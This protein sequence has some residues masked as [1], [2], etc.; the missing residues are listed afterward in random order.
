MTERRNRA[1]NGGTSIA[2]R[3]QGFSLRT[4]LIGLVLGA[5][6]LSLIV[7]VV[8]STQYVKT[9][10][11]KEINQAGK[12]L[13]TVLSLLDPSYFREIRGETG[14]VTGELQKVLEKQRKR[15]KDH[16]KEIR[17]SLKNIQ[18][19]TRNIETFIRKI[20]SS[21]DEYQLQGKTGRRVRQKLQQIQESTK[22]VHDQVEKILQRSD[23]A[24]LF[25]KKVK[26][27]IPRVTEQ[28]RDATGDSFLQSLTGKF[29]IRYLAFRGSN[30]ETGEWR[31]S[32]LFAVPASGLKWD[33]LQEIE[34]D[35]AQNIRIQKPVKL[36]VNQGDRW[37]SVGQSRM[38]VKTARTDDP[39]NALKVIAVLDAEKI[40]QTAGRM[41][42]PLIG[43]AVITL[44]VGVTVGWWFSGR[45]T[46]PIQSLL[47][48]IQEVSKGDLS[49][50]TVPESKD[51]IGVLA[52][53]F[54]RMTK[55]LK[56][57]R[58]KELEAREMK[59]E[60]ELAMNVQTSLLPDW[61]PA[62]ESTDLDVYYRPSKDV[63]GDYYDF[64]EIGEDHLG[65]IV[66]D[67]SGKGVPGSMVMTMARSML[68]MEAQNNLSTAETL[69]NTNRVLAEDIRQGMFITCMYLILDIPENRIRVSS[70]GHNP[71]VLWR[72]QSR[73]VTTVNPNG[74]A[75]GFEKGPVFDQ[76]LEEKQFSFNKGD[77]FV[78]YT[79]GIVE[80]M[81][82]EEQEFGE[83]RFY[84]LVKSKSRKDS[85]QFTKAIVD[86]LDE[87][88]GEAEQHDDITIL[89]GRRVS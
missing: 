22:L 8:M 34:T 85:S 33:D 53:T 25:W 57:A 9:E 26:T 63:G 49:H 46:A 65:I 11:E 48:D 59:H 42:N 2:D 13:V 80:A 20:K 74:I 24:S 72:E 1:D 37:Q 4:K 29:S 66:A 3:I 36:K 58:E 12:Q 10:M 78:L 28:L 35:R 47:V 77:R 17:N 56:T 54:D 81:N 14:K 88:K 6:V 5:Q 64:I 62:L 45:I 68:R 67:V 43:F 87:Y 76:S 71:L 27:E 7:M 73:Q 51:E 52:R 18:K 31:S 16:R 40:Q 50:R 19:N 86:Q 69:K 75:L 23:R 38:F 83:D 32:A 84:R 44:L 55:S 61:K 15:S 30:P 60:L 41:R 82:E 21:F 89:T 70:A 79:D 39:E